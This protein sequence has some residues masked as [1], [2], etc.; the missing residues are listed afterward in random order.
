VKIEQV[1]LDLESVN[2]DC[3]DSLSL[4]ASEDEKHDEEVLLEKENEEI[5]FEAENDHN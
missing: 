2:D 5:G 3:G 1:E 4:G